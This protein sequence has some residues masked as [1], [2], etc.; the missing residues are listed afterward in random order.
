MPTR[1]LYIVLFILSGFTSFAQRY[2]VQGSLAIASP[3]SCNLSDYANANLQNLALN[4]TLADMTVANKRVRLKLFVQTQNAIIAQSTDNVQGEPVI[5]LDGGIPQ[6]FTNTE[7]APYFRQ[8]N[9]QGIVPDAYARSLPEGVYT[10]S[11][12]VYDYFTGNRL[13]G[14]IGQTFWL[15]IND[16]PLLNTPADKSKIADF[17]SPSGSGGIVFNWTPRSTQVSNTEYELTLCELW[18]PAGDPYQQFLAAIPK[19]KTTVSNATT[20]IYTLADPPLQSGYWYAWRV[21]AKAKAGFEDVGLY[22]NDGYSNLYTFR[23]GDPCPAPQNLKA[24][25]KS[26]DQINLTW[27]APAVSPLSS[28]EGAGE[29]YKVAYRKYN[30]AGNYSWTETDATNAFY[31][32]TNLE[33]ATEYEFKVGVLCSSPLGGGQG[34]VIYTSSQRATTLQTGQIKGVDCGKEPAIDISNRNPISLLKVGDVVMAGDFPVTLFKI[35]GTQVSWSG[36]GWVRVPW[37]ADT[38]IHVTF[39]NIQV[40]TDYKLIAGSFNTVYDPKGKNIADVDEAINDAKGIVTGGTDVG[41]VVTGEATPAITVPYTITPADLTGSTFTPNTTGGG[42]ITLASGQTIEMASVPATVQDAVGTIYQADKDG[43]LTKVGSTGGNGATLLAAANLTVVDGL[44]GSVTFAPTNETKYAF[45]PWHKVYDNNGTWKA[46]YESLAMAGGGSYRVSS[47]LMVPDEADKVLALVTLKDKSLMPDSIRFVNGKGTQF[48]TRKITDTSFELSLVGGPA[49]DAQEVY[50]LYPLNGKSYTLGKL[51]VASYQPRTIKLSLVPVNGTALNEDAIREKLAAIYEPLGIDFDISVEDN[52]DHAPLRD[53][54]LKVEG[55]GLLSVYTDQ[56]KE[57]N[58]AF[59]ASGNYENGTVYLFV[60]PKG[61]D[62]NGNEKGLEGDMPRGQQFGY[63]FAEGLNDSQLALAAAH[64]IGHGV[65]QLQHTFSYSGI[66]QGV[67]SSNVM[68]YPAGDALSKLQWDLIHD[69]GLLI[70]VFE[71]D[72]GVEMAGGIAYVADKVDKNGEPITFKYGTSECK[73]FTVDKGWIGKF[74]D[75]DIDSIKAVFINQSGYLVQITDLNN[76]VYKLFSAINLSSKEKQRSA[77]CY[78]VNEKKIR[79]DIKNGTVSQGLKII[80]YNNNA[81]TAYQLT[82]KAIDAYQF[83]TLAVERSAAGKNILVLDGN[84][85]KCHTLTEWDLTRDP[86]H[87]VLFV[88]GYRFSY[89]EKTHKDDIYTSDVVDEGKPYWAGIDD[90]FKTR[91][92]CANVYY[93]DGQMSITTSNHNWDNNVEKS[94]AKFYCSGK[95]VIDAVPSCAVEAGIKY[96]S[97]AIELIPIVGAAIKITLVATDVAC[98]ATPHLNTESNPTGFNIRRQ[99]GANGSGEAFLKKLMANPNIAKNSDGFITDT[100]DIVCHSMGYAYALGMIDYLKGKVTFGRLYI[101]APEDAGAGGADWTQFSEVWQYGSDESNDPISKQDGIAPQVPCPGIP[102]LP[103]NKGGRAYI[104]QN[105][106][107]KRG[108]YSS[109]SIG[110][111]KWIFDI[112]P[113]LPYPQSNGYVKQR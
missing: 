64:E 1:I 79:A 34:E 110:N 80:P 13:S 5:V 81:D 95:G 108:F 51:L 65:F 91:L 9:L 71:T 90:L 18:D 14:R 66:K 8:E 6:R 98:S 36:E 101:I 109:H 69:P 97:N 31:N 12:E 104:P 15:I 107:V 63:L 45:D 25:A 113:N 73:Y 94:M 19:Y 55:S 103:T 48:A 54:P 102:N 62:K 68:D 92:K 82:G 46:K 58:N 57:L 3:Y 72:K 47:K 24:E 83:T 111:Y 112:K 28:G 88:S 30:L 4:L 70:G 7:L 29:R 59:V 96:G 23:Y 37:L 99:T 32:I 87:S 93:A 100:L 76:N 16:P 10:I 105:G 41:K 20:F 11:F 56:M 38:R 22:R 106:T 26:H 39:R 42:T 2:P 21:R 77:A 86:H 40:N 74:S 35:S 33:P 89:P 85:F 84:T 17:S 52:F 53:T 43:K 50:A 27:D 61:A 67:L 78:L 75:K 60:L 44:K 49:G